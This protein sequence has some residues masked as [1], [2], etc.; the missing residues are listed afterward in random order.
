[1]DN[2]PSALSADILKFISAQDD[3]YEDAACAH[4]DAV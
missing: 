4:A 1:M 2:H 3:F